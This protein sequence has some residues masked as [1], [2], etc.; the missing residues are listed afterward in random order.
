MHRART[1]QYHI[2]AWSSLG[3]VID[4][5][6]APGVTFGLTDGVVAAAVKSLGDLIRRSEPLE[7]TCTASLGNTDACQM[8][9]RLQLCLGPS[10]GTCESAACGCQYSV[11]A[12]AITEIAKCQKSL[13]T[14]LFHTSTPLI[15]DLPRGASNQQ[16]VVPSFVCVEYEILSL[17]TVIYR[18]L[19]QV[20]IDVWDFTERSLTQ[21]GEDLSGSAITSK[22]TS[23]NADNERGWF[24]PSGLRFATNYSAKN[25]PNSGE[26]NQTG[27]I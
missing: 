5:M 19:L 9:E 11:P 6:L 1:W 7:A 2:P 18:N 20:L 13:A 22:T 14:M 12:A 15:S 4:C 24:A 21:N 27:I 17:I 25:A 3:Y 10:G 26:L 16:P 23:I 8:N